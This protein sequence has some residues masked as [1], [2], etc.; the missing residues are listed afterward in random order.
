MTPKRLRRAV[1]FIEM[2]FVITIIGVLLAVAL[3]NM[4]GSR[5]GA[6]LRSASRDLLAAGLLARQQAI[7]SGEP[8]FLVLYPKENQW[9]I[10][11]FDEAAEQDRR[12]QDRRTRSSDERVRDLPTRIGF[13]KFRNDLGEI[14]PERE[15]RLTFFPNGTSSGL[16]MQVQDRRGSTLVVDFDRGT[17]RPEVYAG[18]PKTFVAKLREQG[19]DPAEFGLFDDSAID[20]AQARLGEG[21]KRVA[22]WNEEERVSAYKDAV[23]RMLERSRRRHDIQ[24]AGG[25]AA[26]YTEAARWGR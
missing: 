15:V 8:T 5:D 7:V 2:M 11:F 25:P 13:G 18:E 26:Y 6:A 24:E 4:T 1:T 12:W 23:E 10:E 21:F 14:T 17:G 16:A 19:F 20:P 9:R 3:P 22:G